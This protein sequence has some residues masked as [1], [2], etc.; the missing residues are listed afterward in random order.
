MAAQKKLW[1][2][3][4]AAG[5]LDPDV[6][7]FLSSLAIDSR[8]LVE[9]ITG[10]MAHAR[11]LGATGIL[12]QASAGALVAALQALLAEA[13]EGRLRVDPASEDVHS[14]VENELTARLGDAGRAVHAGRSRN[15]QVALDLRLWLRSANASIRKAI[16]EALAAILDLAEAQVETIMPGYTHLQRAQPVTFAHHLLAWAAA[17]ERDYGRFI[18]ADARADECPLGSG[19]LAGSSLPLDREMVARELGFARPSRNSMDS[20]GDRDAA[21]EFAFASSMLA[22]HLSR[23]GEEICLWAGAEYGFVGLS[24]SISTGSSIMPQKRNPDPAELVRGK[25]GRLYGD[26]LNL[27]T[28]QKGLPLAYDRDLQEDKEAVFDAYD[29]VHASL[30]AFAALVRGIEPRVDRMLEAAGGGFAWATD[31]AELLVTKGVPFRTAYGLGKAL[32]E[33]CR[34]RGL[35]DVAGLSREELA[36]VHPVLGELGAAALA[37]RFSP[38]ACVAARDLVG[39]PAPARTRAEIGRLRRF[40]AA[41]GRGEKVPSP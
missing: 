10:S 7:A 25:A 14:Y 41:E 29:T 24:P 11:M 27:L 6:E 36:A 21:T 3:A 18:D 30:R 19:A 39:G 28:M 16:L 17:L 34:A 1:A 26:L 37:E 15:D 33:A 38:S 2:G 12:D 22:T 31:A 8:L 20:V 23:W 4:G 35:D 13:K 5:G 9:D 32:V 40:M